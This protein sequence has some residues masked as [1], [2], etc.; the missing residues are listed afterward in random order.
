LGR[1]SALFILGLESGKSEMDEIVPACSAGR[2]EH[3]KR[4]QKLGSS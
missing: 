3:H 2:S 4:P 1:R